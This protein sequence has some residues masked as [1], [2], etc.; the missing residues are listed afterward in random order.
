MPQE[1]RNLF[2]IDIQKEEF[3]SLWEKVKAAHE[4]FVTNKPIVDSDDDRDQAKHFIRN[5]G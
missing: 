4:V 5:V 3:K 2:M 1:S